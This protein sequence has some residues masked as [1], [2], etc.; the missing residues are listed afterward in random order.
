[1]IDFHTHCNPDLLASR[2]MLRVKPHDK[3]ETDGTID[4][5]RN[6]AARR[7]IKKCVVLNIVNRPEH[8]KHVNEFTLRINAP[9]EKIISFGSVHP[10][11]ENAVREVE[12]LYECGIR[13]IKFQTILQEFALDDPICLPVFRRIGEL[14]MITVIHSGRSFHRSDY[15]VLPQTLHNCID[16][17]GGAP[18]ICAHMGGWLL[19]KNEIAQI[20]KMPIYTDTAF[21]ANNMDQ[22]KFNWAADEFGPDRIL[23]GTDMPWSSLDAEISYIRNCPFSEA[24]KRAV[25]EGN[26]VKLLKGSG[27]SI[28]LEPTDKNIQVDTWK[29]F[30]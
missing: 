26:A 12:F 30:F 18:V 9:G 1:M 29:L 6:L 21:S 28:P 2:A 22:S 13:G 27:L 8:Q 10:Y 7:N 16:A 23:F 24:E 15:Y 4:G 17:F 5:Q 19:E 3:P 14:R 25:F 11:S 20:A